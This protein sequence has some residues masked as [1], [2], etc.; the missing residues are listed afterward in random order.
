MAYLDNVKFLNR[1]YNT[2]PVTNSSTV[3]TPYLSYLNQE[4]AADIADINKIALEAQ[5]THNEWI[6]ARATAIGTA[7]AGVFGWIAMGIFSKKAA[8][9][10]AKLNGL[11]AKLNSLAQEWQEGVTLITYVTQLTKQ[12]DDIDD[13]MDT[14]IKAMTELAALFSAQADCYD[15]IAFNL[16]GMYK[17]TDTNSA[18][19]RKAWI[20]FFMKANILKLKEVC[21]SCSVGNW[22]METTDWLMTMFETNIAQGPG[23]RVCRGHHPEY[24]SGHDALIDWSWGL[25]LDLLAVSLVFLFLEKE[26]KEEKEEIVV[27]V[28][29]KSHPVPS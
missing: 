24:R 26:E 4:V 29:N 1:Q 12:C 8:D 6:K 5:Q 21:S 7:F 22:K 15:K 19:N 13:K 2:G 17:G 10:E 18:N 25:L 23:R 28:W 16:N 20:N 27:S 11:K 14:A 9:L 3:K